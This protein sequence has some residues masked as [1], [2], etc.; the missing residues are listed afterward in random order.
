MRYVSHDRHRVG[1]GR[2]SAAGAGC[3]SY[4]TPGCG[5]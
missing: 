5:E 4:T 3:H 2:V 1:G